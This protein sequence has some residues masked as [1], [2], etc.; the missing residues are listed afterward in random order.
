MYKASVSEQAAALPDGVVEVSETRGGHLVQRVRA[1]RHP[2]A[3]DE[4][5]AVGGE[6]AGPG[7]Y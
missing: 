5:V 3:A 6:D 2:L 4:P 7:P 1:G